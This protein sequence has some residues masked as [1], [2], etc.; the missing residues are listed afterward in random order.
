MAANNQPSRLATTLGENIRFA[1][2]AR[3][4]T[5]HQL[6]VV[7]K[8]GD[9]QAISRWERG[10]NRPADERL[11]ALAEALGVTVAWLYTDHAPAPEQAA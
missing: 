2:D 9:A 4:L 11:I 5:Q 8:T 10:I 7:L 3:G 1:R 6:A